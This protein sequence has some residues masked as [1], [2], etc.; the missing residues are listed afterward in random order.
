MGR[1]GAI[2]AAAVLAVAA[3]GGPASADYYNGGLSSRTFSVRP[4]GINDTWIG[5]LDTS[6]GYWNA[7]SA[8]AHLTRSSTSKNTYTAGRWNYSWGGRYTPSGSGSSRTFKVEVNVQY[9]EARAGSNL[10]KWILSTT[11]HELGHGL[12][13]ADNPGTSRA[14]LMKYDRDPAKIY[15]PQPYDVSEVVKYA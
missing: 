8:G 6:R 7:T 3:G 2:G 5:Y 12:K 14:S 1:A 10:T 4:V 15:K 13:L 9:L 11:T